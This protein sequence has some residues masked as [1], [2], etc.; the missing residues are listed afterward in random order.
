MTQAAAA[1]DVSLS[2][3]ERAVAGSPGMLIAFS[4]GVDS[5]VLLA[6]AARVL[7]DR[8]AAFTADSPSMPRTALR[9]AVEF[10][11]QLQVPHIIERTSELEQEAYRRNDRERCYWCKHTLFSRCEAAA[12][13]A[14]FAELAYGFTAD[15]VS[16]HRPGHRAAVE[17]GVRS[18]LLE[19]RL[20]KNEIRAIAKLLGLEL[21][22]KPAAPCLASRI[23]YGSPVSEE[24]LARIEAIEELLHE[25]G[26]AVSR[27]RYDGER[28]RIE[29]EQEALG[30]LRKP[31][32]Y[33]RIARRAESLGIRQLMIDPEGF[34][35]GKLNDPVPFA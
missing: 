35:S 3:L 15:D 25:L 31:N 26:F 5:A 1:P 23:P 14:G 30:R 16:D 13:E 22:D 8:V 24:K 28:M 9:H 17:F 32:V 7:P 19:A 27:A 33:S 2:R 20:G 29:V 10:A 34:R 6:V 11:R 18:P 21:W 12:R 4:G